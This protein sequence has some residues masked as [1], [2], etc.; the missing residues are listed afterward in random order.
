M[1][2]PILETEKKSMTSKSENESN[3][4]EI[5]N[6][7]N[8]RSLVDKIGYENGM[9]QSLYNAIEHLKRSVKS[10]EVGGVQIWSIRYYMQ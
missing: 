10:N 9:S 6:G 5:F 7:K 2:H 4:T 8:R 1:R 3:P